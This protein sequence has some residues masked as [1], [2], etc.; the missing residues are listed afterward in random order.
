MMKGL[1]LLKTDGRVTEASTTTPTSDKI[2]DIL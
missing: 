1:N 2:S